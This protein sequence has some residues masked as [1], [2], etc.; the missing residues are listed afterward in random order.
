MTFHS[1]RISSLSTSFGRFLHVG[2]AA[3]R[4]GGDGFTGLHRTYGPAPTCGAGLLF[5]VRNTL[6]TEHPCS[7]TDTLCSLDAFRSWVAK[8]G[9]VS[10][11]NQICLTAQG[12]AVKAQTLLTEVSVP[13]DDV[14]TS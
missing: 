8:Y 7:Y 9:A 1:Y 14:V 6:T 11:Q 5:V 4:S 13:T 3:G 10:A 2:G 12:K